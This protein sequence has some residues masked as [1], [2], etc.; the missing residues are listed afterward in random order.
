MCKIYTDPL[1]DVQRKP[2]IGWCA[3][4]GAE[5]YGD[6]SSCPDCKEENEDDENWNEQTP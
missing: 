2:P 5:L 1:R 3:R 6:E 4:C